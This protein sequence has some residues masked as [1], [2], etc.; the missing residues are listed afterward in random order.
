MTF[1]ILSNI[2]DDN[3][4]LASAY[5]KYIKLASYLIF[6]LMVG[7]AAV[8]QPLVLLLL[9]EKWMM[10][11]V[12]LQILCFDWMFD[13]FKHHKFKPFICKGAFRLG[14]TYGNHKKKL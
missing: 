13:H 1:P 11:A 9:T 7:L 14:F 4:R 2:Q 8:A 12:L 10:A 6:P 3:V 5:R